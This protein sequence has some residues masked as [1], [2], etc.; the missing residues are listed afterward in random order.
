MKLNKKLLIITSL[1]P[2]AMVPFSVVSCGNPD[3]N[4]QVDLPTR[5][6]PDKE[7]KVIATNVFEQAYRSLLNDNA[8]IKDILAN[9]SKINDILGK[10]AKQGTKE[11]QNLA[12]IIIKNLHGSVEVV[13]KAQGYVN[14]IFSSAN[15]NELNILET[16]L[17]NEFTKFDA[18][19][20][21]IKK[22][23]QDHT[24]L[25]P[26]NR[27]TISKLIKAYRTY[28]SIKDGH[29]TV[30]E[31]RKINDALEEGMVNKQL[32]PYIQ[33]FYHKWKKTN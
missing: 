21:S 7:N 17:N 8:K 33:N 25:A 13:S 27:Q 5:D 19:D 28:L 2:I 18:V 22:A 1:L 12:N 16:N 26:K 10:L 20:S 6:K 32:K 24:V 31:S 11:Q 30:E 29:F 15:I 4:D 3:T 9:P 14:S 23:I